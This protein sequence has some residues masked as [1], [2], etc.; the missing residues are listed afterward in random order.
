VV[1]GIA[2]YKL[3]QAVISLASLHPIPLHI[4]HPLLKFWS[5]GDFYFSMGPVSLKSVLMS[6]FGTWR[7]SFICTHRKFHWMITMDMNPAHNA[8][9]FLLNGCHG[10]DCAHSFTATERGVCIC[11]H[12]CCRQGTKCLWIS[13]HLK[14]M[15]HEYILQNISKHVSDFIASHPRKYNIFHLVSFPY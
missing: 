15:P 14:N 10:T 9:S 12:M 11:T 7:F 3:Q 1:L 4:Q 2:S 6:Q 8:L 13:E 5:S